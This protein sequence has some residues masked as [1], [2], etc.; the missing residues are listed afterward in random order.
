M[1][2]KNRPATV[3]FSQ[4]YPLVWLLQVPIISNP[5]RRSFLWIRQHR[6]TDCSSTTLKTSLVAGVFWVT[7]AFSI[8]AYLWLVLIVQ[9]GDGLVEISPPVDRYL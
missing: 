7:A 1:G 2:K 5:S 8:F 4:A 3:P 6:D 9:V